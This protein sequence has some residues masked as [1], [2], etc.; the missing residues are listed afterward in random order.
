MRNVGVSVGDDGVA[1]RVGRRSAMALDVA[2]LVADRRP[3]AHRARG[4]I[5]GAKL[6]AA[7]KDPAAAQTRE[8][9]DRRGVAEVVRR[10][11]A[12]RVATGGRAG[13]AGADAEA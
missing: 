6:A 13:D 7:D 9:H 12:E 10:G 3:R 4:T 5:E 1:A 8:A 2:E 11:G